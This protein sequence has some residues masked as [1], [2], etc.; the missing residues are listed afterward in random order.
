MALIQQCIDSELEYTELEKNKRYYG[1][2]DIG[3]E[4]DLTAIIILEKQDD[5]FKIIYK[6][7]MRNTPYNEQMNVFNYL[8]NNYDFVKFRIDESGIGNMMAEELSRGHSIE[9][10]TFTNENKQELVGNLK[11]Y[12]AGQTI[13]DTRRPHSDK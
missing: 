12:D 4:Q 1:G 7:T 11:T 10:V 13:K 9:C 5:L 3:R 8:L 2:A 6:N